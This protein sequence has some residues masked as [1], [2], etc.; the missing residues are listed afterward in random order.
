M[1]EI[2]TVGLDLAKHMFQ[3]RSVDGANL[4]IFRKKMRWDEGVTPSKPV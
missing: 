2:I 3:V 1:S 4:A